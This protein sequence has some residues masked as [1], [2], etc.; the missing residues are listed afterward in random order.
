MSNAEKQ[1]AKCRMYTCHIEVRVEAIW[2]RKDYGME[3]EIA[4]EKLTSK[5]QEEKRLGL[6]WEGLPIV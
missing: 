6:D 3:I 5:K 4:E 1:Q 2:M